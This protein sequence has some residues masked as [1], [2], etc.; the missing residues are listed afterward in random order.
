VSSYVR[1]DGFNCPCGCGRLVVGA[2]HRQFFESSCAA[3]MRDK[4]GADRPDRPS[5]MRDQ[6]IALLASGKPTTLKALGAQLG[7]SW[8]RVQQ[9]TKRYQLE[10]VRPAKQPRLSACTE[11]GAQ[12]EGRQRRC[13][14]CRSRRRRVVVVCP[15]CLQSREIDE[16]AALHN[17]STVCRSCYLRMNNNKA[18]AFRPATERHS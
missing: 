10:D 16:S 5:A 9:L 6:L 3:R 14:T 1:K 17:K 18:A 12:F 11:C 7:V 13:P 8:Q 4:A 2:T 15:V